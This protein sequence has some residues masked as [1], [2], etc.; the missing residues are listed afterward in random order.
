[1]GIADVGNSPTSVF[2]IPNKHLGEQNVKWMQVLLFTIQQRNYE[3]FEHILVDMDE[4][5]TVHHPTLDKGE[6]MS[7]LV[8]LWWTSHECIHFTHN[9]SVKVLSGHPTPHNG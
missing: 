5:V 2:S 7:C 8:T 3:F 9:R 1:M 6:I 4:S